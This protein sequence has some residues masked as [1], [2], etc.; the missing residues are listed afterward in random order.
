MRLVMRA[1][2]V[3]ERQVLM[4]AVF[5]VFHASTAFNYQILITVLL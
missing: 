4:R 5:A 1:D 2:E 3:S